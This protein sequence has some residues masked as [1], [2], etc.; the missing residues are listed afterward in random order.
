MTLPLRQ[1]AWTLT[2]LL[3]VVIALMSLRLALPH[4]PGVAPFIT[5]NPFSTPFLP[6]HAITASVALL[7]GAFQFIATRRGRRAAWHRTIGVGYVAC[8][9]VS[10]PPALLL[11][12]GSQAGPVATVGFGLLAVIWFYCNAQGLRAVL[13]RRYAEHGEWMIRSYA[14]TLAA[15]S[16]RLQ[17]PVGAMLGLQF[18]E[19]YVLTAFSSWIPNLMLAE[20]WIVSRRRRLTT[21]A[22]A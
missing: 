19:I 11:A 12:L 22:P 18:M 17:L 8:C 21:T 10:A 3:S 4:P 13:D 15:V 9:L 2:A 20:L 5:A 16:L 6:M 14:L 7:L 1:I